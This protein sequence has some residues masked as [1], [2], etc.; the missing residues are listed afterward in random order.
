MRGEDSVTTEFVPSKR[1]ATRKYG[2]NRIDSRFRGVALVASLALTSAGAFWGCG[3]DSS[4]TS[5]GSSNGAGGDG[6]AR[7]AGHGRHGHRRRELRARHGDVR[8]HVHRDLV[9]PGEL[10]RL[11][12]GVRRGRGLLD[13]AVRRDVRGLDALQW[14]MRR[15]AER[16]GELRRRAAP[17]VR[18]ARR[19][20]T[21]AASAAAG[22]RARARSAMAPA[23]TR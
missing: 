1:G 15:H 18:R 8:E 17:R 13:G 5:S 7:A 6:T 16:S 12:H 9:R 20:R 14:Q 10:R 19:V 21:G 4:T 22:R 23:S 11:R 2:M 3:G